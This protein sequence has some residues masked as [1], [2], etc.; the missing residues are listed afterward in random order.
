MRRFAGVEVPACWTW[1]LPA[2][3]A[4]LAGEDDTDADVQDER[5]ER[6]AEWQADRCALCG[7]KRG[8]L[9]KDH[10]H[11]TGMMRGWLCHRCNT[12]ESGGAEVFILYRWI[13]PASVC[14]VS[15]LYAQPQPETI[16]DEVGSD[17]IRRILDSA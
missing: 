8:K 12:R 2:G 10:D 16:L 13:N 14:G 11:R 1:R 9:V 17:E 3:A 4:F 7:Q 6:M 5:W 15:Y